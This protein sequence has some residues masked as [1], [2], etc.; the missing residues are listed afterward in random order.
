MEKLRNGQQRDITLEVERDR[1]ALIQ[2]TI[3]Q[4]NTQYNRR[5]SAGGKFIY[6]LS[7]FWPVTEL[8]SLS[9]RSLA[10]VLELCRVSNFTRFT[11]LPL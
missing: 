3:K 4:L 2:Q 10:K 11:T 7:I 6:I 5:S 9:K 1:A 8:R